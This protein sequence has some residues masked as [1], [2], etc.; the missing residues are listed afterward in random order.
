MKHVKGII[1]LIAMMTL[2]VAAWGSNVGTL[3]VFAPNSVIS[4]AAVNSNFEQI[5]T[6]VNSKQD[7]VTGK[8]TTAQGINTVN[9]NGTVLCST[10]PQGDITS[11]QPTTGGGLTGGGIAGNVFLGLGTGTVTATHLGANSVGTSEV[12]DNSLTANDLASNSVGFPEIASGAVRTAEILDGQVFGVDIA[13][14]T[15][16]SSDI[17]SAS[18]QRRVTGTCPSGQSAM[19]VVG[20]TGA[21]TCQPV[22]NS[23]SVGAC[24]PQPCVTVSST[25]TVTVRS[26]SVTKNGTGRVLVLFN[27]FA[28]C[29]AGTTLDLFFMAAQISSSSTA[30]ASAVGAGSIEIRYRPAR[31]GS[32][33]LPMNLATSFSVSGTTSQTFYVRARLLSST[34]PSCAIYSG[35]MEAI[36]I[37]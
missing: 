11:V 33:S 1:L 3:N 9:A 20:S 19:R 37:P 16:T 28:Y 10:I 7:R 21:V 36:F 34:V 15:I 5:K 30:T 13:N 26:V 6:A 35:N 24:S 18:V 8:C 23:G 17:S 32:F 14:G 12:A 25:T 2:I 31:T 22:S 4:S 29:I 27:G